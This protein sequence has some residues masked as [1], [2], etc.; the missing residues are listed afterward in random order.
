M[1]RHLYRTVGST[2]LTTSAFTTLLT[3]IEA[4]LNSRPLTAPSTDINDHLALT[5]GHFII[6]RPITA[7][8]EPSS[9]KNNTLSRH[10]RN[11]DK[12]IRQFWKKWSVEYF[13]SLQQRNKWRTANVQPAVDKFFIIKDDNNPPM[14]W[15]LARRIQTFDG[16]DNIV[17]VVQVKTQ[18]G[19]YI[20]PVTR[21]IPHHREA[22]EDRGAD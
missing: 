20:R 9:T 6:R 7:I 11:I 22:P 12:M 21:L 3:Q 4:I 10:W 5:P 14:C 2:K 1:K 8:A 15:P 18:T 19:V 13:S 17:L 16:N